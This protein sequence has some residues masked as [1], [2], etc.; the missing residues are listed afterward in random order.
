MPLTLGLAF[1]DEEVR[2]IPP[3]PPPQICH[4]HILV[5]LS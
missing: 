3:H 1:G 4:L 2:D 5:I